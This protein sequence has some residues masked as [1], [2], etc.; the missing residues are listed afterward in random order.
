MVCGG[1][2]MRSKNKRGA[3]L[4]LFG[5]GG[6]GIGFRRDSFGSLDLSHTA[7]GSA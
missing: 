1:N 7:D 4:S 6:G 2:E 5:G 3:C